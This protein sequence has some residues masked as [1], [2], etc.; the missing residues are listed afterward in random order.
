MTTSTTPPGM[1]STAS[2]LLVEDEPD[3]ADAVAGYL[4]HA[5]HRVLLAG[6]GLSGLRL[7]FGERPD[8]VIL[9]LMLPGLSGFEVLRAVRDTGS[10]P[11]TPV[12]LLTARSHESD[13]LEGFAIGADDYVTKPFR[14][15]ELVARVQAIL[16]RKPTLPEHLLGLHGLRLLP[17]RREAWLGEQRLE[18]TANEFSLL[19][20]LL[21]HPGRVFRRAELLDARNNLDTEALERTVDAHIRNLRRKIGAEHIETVYGVGYRYPDHV[22]HAE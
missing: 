3:L 16:R 11:Q 9:D 19:L 5:G 21:Q 6:D 18:L 8:L 17:E 4:R 2:V 22:D 13:V 12:L 15:R 10:G 7:F 20:S 1:P 14:P